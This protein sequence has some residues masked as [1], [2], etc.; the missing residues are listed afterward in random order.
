MGWRRMLQAKAAAGLRYAAGKEGR[1]R[2]SAQAPQK[3]VYGIR[4]NVSRLSRRLAKR[5][6][7]D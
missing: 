6:I 7:D 3:C 2:E 4:D 1:E 5:L